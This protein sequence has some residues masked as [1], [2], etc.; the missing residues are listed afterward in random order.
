M[1]ILYRRTELEAQLHQGMS[2]SLIGDKAAYNQLLTRIASLVRGYLGNRLGPQHRTDERIEDLVQDVLIAIHRKKH[3]YQ[4]DKPFLPWLFAVA[5]YRLIDH[6][7]H[8]KRRPSFVEINETMDSPEVTP[9]LLSD[10]QALQ[11]EELL[12]SLSGRQKEILMLAKADGL[13]MADIAKRLDLSV[14]SVKVT[15]HRTLKKLKK[16]L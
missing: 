7:R 12:N 11:L 4:L 15:L 3:L 10:E 14:A 5:R 8:E 6:I 16:D 13:S 2:L 9:T 1:T